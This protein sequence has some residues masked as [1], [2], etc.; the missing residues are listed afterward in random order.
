MNFTRISNVLARVSK[1]FA[2]LACGLIAVLVTVVVFQ[3][4]VTNNTPS[5]AE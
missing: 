1:T 2:A 4:F 5:W 3:R